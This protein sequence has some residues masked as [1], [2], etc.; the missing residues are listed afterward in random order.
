M[1]SDPSHPTSHKHIIRDVFSI[2]GFITIGVGIQALSTY[3]IPFPYNNIPG[4]FIFLSAMVPWLFRKLGLPKQ[5]KDAGVLVGKT[6]AYLDFAN[7]INAGKEPGE[8]AISPSPRPEPK[9]ALMLIGSR[10]YSKMGSLELEYK[11]MGDVITQMVD[12]LRAAPPEDDTGFLSSENY[13]HAKDVT[14]NCNMIV[15]Y[16]RS[17]QHIWQFA[18]KRDGAH[19]PAWDRYMKLQRESHRLGTEIGI[20]HEIYEISNAEGIYHNMPRMGLGDMW[21]AVKTENGST[22][23]RNSLVTGTGL[24]TSSNGRLGYRDSQK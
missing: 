9:L 16:W 15:L 4:L 6:A 12:E 11:N 20:W 1:P 7:P 19:Y 17:Y 10:C 5:D 2:Q 13:M 21:D 14:G 18:H 3:F 22:V 24:Y 23:Y 8:L